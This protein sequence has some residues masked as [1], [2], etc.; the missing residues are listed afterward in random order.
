MREQAAFRER[1]T[2]G[3]LLAVPRCQGDTPRMVDGRCL[4]GAVR[5]RIATSIKFA[6]HCHCSMCRR[7]HGAAFATYATVGAKHV[8]VEDPRGSLKRYRSSEHVERSFCGECGSSLFWKDE[9]Y[10]KLLE[11][12][13]GTMGTGVDHEP[14][15]HIF[16]GS[17][18]AWWKI[19]DDLP[20][21][22][23][24]VPAQDD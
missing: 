8:A 20:Q 14:D 17:R 16:V 6:T 18:A 22:E 1:R 9:R 12:S 11:V 23:A 19:T 10:P 21:H 3:A 13:L 5:Y 4:C 2:V 24:N 15:A 7:Q